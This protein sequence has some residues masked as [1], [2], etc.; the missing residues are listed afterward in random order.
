MQVH[1]LL[2]VL[3]P[4]IPEP[5]PDHLDV[6]EEA[7]VADAE[8]DEEVAVVDVVVDDVDTILGDMLGSLGE[9]CLW[10]GLLLED[11]RLV[12]GLLPLGDWRCWQLL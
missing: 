3:V 5:L 2:L 12:V 6:R 10:I 11:R 4:C 9:S 7:I 1:L 8:L